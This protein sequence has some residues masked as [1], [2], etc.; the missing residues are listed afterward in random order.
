MVNTLYIFELFLDLELF[1]YNLPNR[2]VT[3]KSIVIFL[4][5]KILK[6]KFTTSVIFDLKYNETLEHIAAIGI[7]FSASRS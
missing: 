5:V 4:F 7:I 3:K 1:S 2:D 6:F